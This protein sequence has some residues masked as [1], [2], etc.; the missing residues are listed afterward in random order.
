MII[1]DNGHG[2]LNPETGVYVTP[3]K[4]SPV[5]SDGTQLFEGVFNREI[6]SRIKELCDDAGIV[7]EL[8]VP[9]W[10]DISLSERCRRANSL[11]KNNPDAI[12][13]SVHA[14]AFNKE[15]ANGFSIYTSRGETKSDAIAKILADEYLKEMTEFR[16]RGLKEAGFAMV[17]RTNCPAVLIECAFMTNERE[18]K[19]LMTEQDR[20]A[21]AIFDGIQLITVPTIKPDSIFVN[22]LEGNQFR[23]WV[24]H[25]HLG[26][27]QS[28][29]L[30]LTGSH[31]NSFIKNAYAKLGDKYEEYLILMKS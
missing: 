11:Y 28:V 4:R 22:R 30:D 7:C 31:D 25:Y 3:G 13:I 9:E 17:T 8:I 16:M 19:I 15:S 12:L 6:T 10:E 1:L 5:W 21:N 24:H 27:A 26:Y 29:D 18:C 2:A 14:D 23:Q 20:I